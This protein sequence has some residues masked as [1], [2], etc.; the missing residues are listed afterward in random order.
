MFDVRLAPPVALALDDF[1][2]RVIECIR[3][4]E[5]GPLLNGVASL[6]RGKASRSLDGAFAPRLL[7]LCA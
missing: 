1:G 2:D 6:V 7:D 4:H 3:G 5:R